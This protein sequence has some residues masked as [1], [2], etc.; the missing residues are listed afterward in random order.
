MA[1]DTR[2]KIISFDEAAGI[3]CERGARWVAG[4]FDPLLAEHARRLRG[5]VE[6]GKALIVV[7]TD[8][9]DPLLPLRARAE[10]VAALA[11]VSYVVMADPVDRGL[12][13]GLM[14]LIVRRNAG[15]PA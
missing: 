4:E 7:V 2:T 11:D 14:E 5:L 12:T 8:P 15:E 9:A 10:L 3:A 6:E 1:L 13:H